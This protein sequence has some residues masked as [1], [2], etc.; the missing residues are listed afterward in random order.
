DRHAVGRRARGDGRRPRAVERLRPTAPY[1]ACDDV[2]SPSADRE[3]S[4]PRRSAAE[5]QGFRDTEL[6]DVAPARLPAAGRGDRCRWPAHPPAAGMVIE[7]QGPA[8]KAGPAASPPKRRGR[9]DK[10]I[11]TL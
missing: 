7:T 2:G 8:Q 5:S 11:Q 9:Y 3:P 4:S 1:R 10:D 6:A